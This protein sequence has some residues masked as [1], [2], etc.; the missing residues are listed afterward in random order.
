MTGMLFREPEGGRRAWVFVLISCYFFVE[1]IFFREGFLDRLLYL[2]FG[3]AV[4]AFGAADL[5]PRDGTRQAGLLRVG[6]L[7]LMVLTLS[8]RVIQLVV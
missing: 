4:L 1:T 7:A 5:L 3:L 2:I 8:V 6:G